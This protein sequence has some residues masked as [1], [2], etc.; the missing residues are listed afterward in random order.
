MTFVFAVR[1]DAAA[2]DCRSSTEESNL[3]EQ[4]NEMKTSGCLLMS[5]YLLKV[6]LFSSMKR[7]SSEQ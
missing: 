6:T 5:D 2:M 3:S 7:G 1:D 4:V